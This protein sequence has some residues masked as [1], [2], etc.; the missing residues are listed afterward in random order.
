VTVER[1]FSGK[2]HCPER[3]GWGCRR[4]HAQGQD[5]G[6]GRDDDRKPAI[7]RRPPRSRGEATHR[8][9]PRPSCAAHGAGPIVVRGKDTI[10]ATAR[11]AQ[12]ELDLSREE[13]EQLIEVT[14]RR[15]MQRGMASV[16][17]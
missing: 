17:V 16:I 15:H 3:P 4:S 1:P 14:W 2:C 12:G 9:R 13:I 11:E 6:A 8:I 5:N 7:H 10:T